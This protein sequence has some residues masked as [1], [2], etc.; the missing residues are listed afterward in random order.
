MMEI[1]RVIALSAAVFVPV[2][3][4]AGALS[5][6]ATRTIGDPRARRAQRCLLAAVSVL[7]A[8]VATALFWASSGEISGEDTY[9]RI[10]RTLTYP[11]AIYLLG[12]VL[13]AWVGR[14]IHEDLTRLKVRKA[15]IYA[16]VLLATISIAKVWLIREQLNYT[17]MISVIGAGLALALHQVLLCVTGWLMLQIQ[18]NYD[19]GDRVQIGEIHGDVSDIG[20]FHTTLVEFG[21]WVGADQ[22]TGRLVTVPNSFVFTK[23]IYNYTR[24]FEYIWN[25]ISVLVTYE[26]N[27]RKAQQL[28]VDLAQEGV[29]DIQEKFRTQIR[30]LA[31]KYMILFQH[32]TPI[33]YPKIVDSGVQLTLRY[34]TEP[35]RRRLTESDLTSRILD[36]FNGE[37]DIDF[38]YPTTRFYDAT[39]EGKTARPAED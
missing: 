12:L 15:F 32:I 2:F 24:G 34:L 8:I 19:V 30:H 4:V 23:P 9:R 10:L 27:W 37:P 39:R 18:R 25:E 13:L 35:K 28:M 11:L 16:G 20:I 14:Y 33:V 3:V 5:Y 22:S 29:E 1:L 17:T 6:L 38:A 31:R 26:S 7:V 21:G 36:G